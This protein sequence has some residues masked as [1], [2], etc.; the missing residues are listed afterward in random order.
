MLISLNN[1]KNVLANSPR[2]LILVLFRLLGNKMCGLK[3]RTLFPSAVQLR[4][5]CQPLE[6]PCWF[7][8]LCVD[9]GSIHSFIRACVRACNFYLSSSSSLDKTYAKRKHPSAL[10]FVI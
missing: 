10:Y 1:I 8:S 2:F 7:F 5:M 3:G 9:L 4:A 6:S